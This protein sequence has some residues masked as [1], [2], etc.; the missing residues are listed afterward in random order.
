M[1]SYEASGSEE[2]GIMADRWDV[3]HAS[4]PS[5]ANGEAEEGEL[6][7]DELSSDGTG[8]GSEADI[9]RLM[10]GIERGPGPN[11]KTGEGGEPN[12]AAT[13]K[14]VRPACSASNS[15]RHVS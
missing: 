10:R 3:Q 12:Y 7:E 13:Q 15:H 9:D 14:E 8:G 11:D 6:D 4:N 1:A 2:S 5:S